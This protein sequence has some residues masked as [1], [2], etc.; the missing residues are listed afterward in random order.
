MNDTYAC[1]SPCNTLEAVSPNF[2]G[3]YTQKAWIFG[4]AP[5]GLANL[6]ADIE[7]THLVPLEEFSFGRPPQVLLIDDGLIVTVVDEGGPFGRVTAAFGKGATLGGTKALLHPTEEL[8]LISKAIV[9]TT[10]RCVDAEL[11][12]TYLKD[13]PDVEQAYLMYIMQCHERQIEG[14]LLTN[15]EPVEMRIARTLLLLL[16]ASGVPLH[17]LTQSAQP[18][19]YNVSAEVL[20]GFVYATRAVI[21]RI[22]ASWVHQGYIRRN[23]RLIVIEPS[24]LELLRHYSDRRS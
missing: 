1:V 24:F 19:R 2:R 23:G 10:V 4:Q 17:A 16:E 5:Q 21:S 14:L 12:R 7:P 8:R 13:H 9:P 3:I 18:L 15:I 20:T 22:L 11:F 6:F